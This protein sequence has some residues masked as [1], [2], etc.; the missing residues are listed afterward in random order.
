MPV[1]IFDDTDFDH[2]G[3]IA[4]QLAAFFTQVEQV[5]ALAGCGIF[6]S[7]LMDGV[8]RGMVVDAE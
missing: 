4:E 2:T 5:Q 1:E 8:E 7:Q 3:R 6:F